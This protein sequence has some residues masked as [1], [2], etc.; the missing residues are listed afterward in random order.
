MSRIVT[1]V[2]I[3]AICVAAMAGAARL[4]SF[5]LADLSAEAKTARKTLAPFLGDP[6]VGTLAQARLLEL[7]AGASDEERRERSRNLLTRA[8]LSGGAWLAF[9]QAGLET[10]EPMA[11]VER[12]LLM[13]ALVGRNEGWLM[14]RRAGFAVPLWPQLSAA[15]RRSIVDDLLGGW[16]GAAGADREALVSIV[17]LSPE[18]TKT[19]IREALLRAGA[20]G[21]TISAEIGLAPTPRER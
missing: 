21:E 5:G 20:A 14:A 16:E 6:L 17:Y 9:A 18:Q 11:K 8:P 10:E 2:V 4:L 12:A 3:I 15:A 1:A 7:D 13:S 19:E